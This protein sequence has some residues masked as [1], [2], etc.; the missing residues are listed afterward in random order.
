MSYLRAILT[1]LDPGGVP[2]PLVRPADAIVTARAS[3]TVVSDDA[4]PGPTAAAVVGAPPRSHPRPPIDEADRSPPRRDPSRPAPEPPQ[5]A[6]PVAPDDATRQ[7]QP[8][9]EPPV[10][11]DHTAEPITRVERVR[12]IHHEH[13]THHDRVRERVVARPER[14]TTVEHRTTVIQ[15][16]IVGPPPP[17]PPAGTTEASRGPLRHTPERRDTSLRDEAA[18]PVSPTVHV[19]IGR[20]V[21]RTTDTSEP[22]RPSRPRPAAP[23]LDLGAYLSQ[24]SKGGS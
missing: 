11:V 4:V 22:A 16:R 18:P 3:E 14:P 2:E 23:A 6:A 19:H 12:E 20:V 8:V 5:P 15:P 24:R 7:D 21:V 17:A 13:H 9:G 10:P 1:R